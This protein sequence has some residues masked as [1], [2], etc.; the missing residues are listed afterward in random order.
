MRVFSNLDSHRYLKIFSHY[1]NLAF[2]KVTANNFYFSAKL[3]SC[4][5]ISLN[6]DLFPSI[7]PTISSTKL[8]FTIPTMIPY[9]LFPQ[10]SPKLESL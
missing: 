7:K 5:R 8:P 10:A 6:Q 4:S 1:A 2:Y 9:L 3:L